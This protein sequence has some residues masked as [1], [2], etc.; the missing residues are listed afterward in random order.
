MKIVFELGTSY[1]KIGIAGEAQPRHFIKTSAKFS[2]MMQANEWTENFE[3]LFC[4]LFIMSLNKYAVTYH[5]LQ[6]SE[7]VLHSPHM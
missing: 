2:K 7:F 5:F 3:Q 4:E 1:C 6:F